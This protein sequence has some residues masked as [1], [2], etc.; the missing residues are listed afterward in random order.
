MS[1][2]GCDCGACCE[3]CGHESN[4]TRY[5]SKPLSTVDASS[6]TPQP[7]SF[8]EFLLTDGGWAS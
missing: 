8:L 5:A 1:L 3:A 7:G 2:P 4:C 6:V